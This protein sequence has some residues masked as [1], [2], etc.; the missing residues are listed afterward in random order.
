MKPMDAEKEN[1]TWLDRPLLSYIPKLNIETLLIILI[2]VVTVFTR[3][4]ILGDRVMSHDV[5]NH[6]VPSY[7]LFQGLGYR[8]DP[9]TH[10][11]L[12]FHLI[13]LTY[14]LFGDNDFT[15]RVPAALFSVATVMAALFC[16]RRY[17]GRIGSLVAGFLFMISPYMLFYGRYT[18]NEALIGLFGVLMLYAMLRYLHLG[19]NRDLYLLTAV[20]VLHYTSKET[21]FIYTAQALLFLAFLFLEQVTRREW[22]KP[23]KVRPFILSVLI[24]FLLLAVALGLAGLGR[25]TETVASP[26]ATAATAAAQTAAAAG[27]LML[28]ETGLVVVA[29]LALVVAIYLLIQGMTWKEIRRERSFDLLVLIGTLVLRLLVA[30]L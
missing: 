10:G 5:V 19:Q 13:A 30:F 27:S 12:Q 21:A 28:A 7:D 22:V 23:E 14:F 1:S 11:P 16:F 8:H 15:S 6:V 20:L 18:R 17:L 24:A 9:V 3:F 4:Y 25:G 2:L 26:D 29:I